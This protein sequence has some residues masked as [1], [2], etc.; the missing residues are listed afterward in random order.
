MK[1][2]LIT[3]FIVTIALGLTLFSSCWPTDQ[4]GFPVVAP[5]KFVMAPVSS[6]KPFGSRPRELYVEQVT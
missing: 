1:A 4:T 6:T 5:V 3:R 2:R